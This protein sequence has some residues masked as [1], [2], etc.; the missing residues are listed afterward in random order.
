VWQ[1][2]LSNK[3]LGSKTL[4]QVQAKPT[5]SPFRK[6]IMRGKDDFFQRGSFVVRDDMKTRF[7]EETGMV[8]LV[9]CGEELSFLRQ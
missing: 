1:E 5:D 6:G 8:Q 4:L 3:Y 9:A 2:L 7:W